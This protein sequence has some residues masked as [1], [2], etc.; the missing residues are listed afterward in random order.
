MLEAHTLQPQ[1]QIERGEM[2]R[3]RHGP[4]KGN[5]R[6]ADTNVRLHGERAHGVLQREYAAHLAVAGHRHV[7]VFALHRPA[8]AVRWHGR[9]RPFLGSDAGVRGDA[10]RIWCARSS[11]RRSRCGR[12]FRCRGVIDLLVQLVRAALADHLGRRFLRCR[13][14]LF[15][16]IADGNHL[17]E[18]SHDGLHVR[19]RDLVGVGDVAFVQADVMQLKIPGRRLRRLL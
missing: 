10:R 8:D 15:H 18:R 2:G 14:L 19:F 12:G 9:L 11:S 4:H 3:V 7:V 16:D 5:M 1:A 17:A 6:I 13:F